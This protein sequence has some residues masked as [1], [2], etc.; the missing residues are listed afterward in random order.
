VSRK[1]D[2]GIDAGFLLPLGA[3]VGV[4]IVVV[5]AMS[6]A[7][8]PLVGASVSLCFI[9]SGLHSS[10]RGKFLVWQ[11]L[12]DGLHLKGDERL[13]DLGCGRG[14]VLCAA[15]RRLPRGLGVGV[16]IWSRTDQSGNSVAAT[17]RNA[18]AEKVAGRVAPL[19]AD[20]RALPFPADT[21]DLVVSNIAIHNIKGQVGRAT[22]I[23]EAVRVLRPGGRLVVADLS[24]TRAYEGRLAQ[25]GM[26]SIGRRSLGWRMWWGG[27][28]R[29]TYL[30]TATKPGDGMSEP[31]GPDRSGRA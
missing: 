28:W 25:L 29:A 20:M 8:A 22:A 16:D 10:L 5:A 23:D 1:A 13:L 18:E 21:F 31:G 6:G 11:E 19:T 12:L 26:A 14:A 30:V 9:G 15:A 3:I 7:V 27:P 2:Y 17:R 24:F 4:A